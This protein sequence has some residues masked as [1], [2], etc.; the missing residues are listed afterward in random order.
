MDKSLSPLVISTHLFFNANNKVM[1]DDTA[2]YPQNQFQMFLV[3]CNL[4]L[5]L[6]KRREC[7]LKKT[8]AMVTSNLDLQTSLSGKA[9]GTVRYT[10]RDDICM[11]SD[12]L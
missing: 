6:L 12:L 5:D 7:T 2:P 11:T 3:I 10:L 1:K 8:N 4:K 9:Y